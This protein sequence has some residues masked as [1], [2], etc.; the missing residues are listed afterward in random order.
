MRFIHGDSLKDVIE[1]FH[2]DAS[3]KRDPGRRSLELRK[4]LRQ[5]LDVCNAIEYAHTRGVLHRDIKPA[6]IIVGRHGETLV[7]DWGLAKVLGRTDAVS[8]DE[9]PLVTSATSGSVE[10]LPGSTLGTPSYMS[11]EQA[12]GDLEHLGPQS[13]VYSLGATLYFLLTGRPPVERDDVRVLL[14]AVQQG[15]FAPPRLHRPVARPGAG[16]DLPQGDGPET[17]GSLLLGRRARRGRG[18]VDG[19]RA[20]DRLARAAR[21]PGAALGAATPH[22]GG[23]R[24]VAMLAG[25]VGLAAVATIQTRANEV[26]R[27]ALDDTRR[28]QAETQAALRQSE[29]SR[30]QAEAVSAF[31]VQAFRSPDPSKDGRQVKVVQRAGRGQPT[32]RQRVHGITGDPGDA[33]RCSGPDVPAGWECSTGPL[34]CTRRPARYSSPHWVPTTA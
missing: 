24:G 25:V 1:R 31:L 6:N 17:R 34:L 11:P 27:R 30:K 14:R 12:R 15:E 13:D 21:P 7:V 23:G 32:A 22:G 10:T 26:T 20:G 4:L 33:A 19:R 28:A 5:F 16:G 2:A 3:Y 29:E 9:R 18:A 8:S